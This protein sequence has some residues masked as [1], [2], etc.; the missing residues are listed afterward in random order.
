MAPIGSDFLSLFYY[1]CVCV[2]A[3]VYAQQNMKLAIISALTVVKIL[4]YLC[5]VCVCVYAS[6]QVFSFFIKRLLLMRC[7]FI[8]LSH[9]SPYA[10]VHN[11]GHNALFIRRSI[12]SCTQHSCGKRTSGRRAFEGALALWGLGARQKNSFSN[13][14]IDCLF[15]FQNRLKNDFLLLMVE[16]L[17][18]CDVIRHAVE[19]SNY[20][21]I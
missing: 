2:C 20:N 11:Q 6:L 1:L 18:E 4:H 13:W 10:L 7:V 3:C 21:S 15:I 14:Q 8:L 9:G 17:Y 16:L 12:V 5:V 19:L